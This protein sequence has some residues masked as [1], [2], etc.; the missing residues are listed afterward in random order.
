[1]NFI[2]KLKPSKDGIFI[3]SIWD[4]GFLS[5]LFVFVNISTSTIFQ[6]VNIPMSALNMIVSV[7]ATIIIYL[8]FRRKQLTN[9]LF[10]II[11]NIIVTFLSICF[12]MFIMNYTMDVT[13]DG[14]YYHKAAIGAIKEGWNP[15]YQNHYDF[16]V[17]NN[18]SIADEK[19]SLWVNSYPKA[20]WNFAASV[21]CV[22]NNIESG[23]AIIILFMISLFCMTFS[24]AFN[25]GFKI[26]QAFLIAFILCM[27]PIVM[28]QLFSYYVDGIMGL[29]IYMTILFL[30]IISDRNYTLIS[31]N[32]KWLGL[33]MSVCICMNIKFTGIL[34][35][36]IFCILFY[37]YWLFKS[38]KQADFKKQF[39]NLTLRFF[40][41]VIVGIGAIGFS[42]Y[43]K[44]IIN[45]NNPLYPLMGKDKVD[46]V[47]T[48]QPKS[49]A[50]KNRFVKLF[51]SVFAESEN[52]TYNS[53]DDPNLKI[54]FTYTGKEIDESSIPDLRIGGYGI[55]F[56]G[57]LILTVA[58]IM[59]TYIHIYIYMRKK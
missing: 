54:P 4:I 44:N 58:I 6:F 33:L 55:L 27:S 56:S 21:Y 10:N 12:V 20:T 31:E 43:M 2:E 11:V 28:S 9:N 15:V 34:F 40:V 46:I 49:F 51:E 24:Y 57:I 18:P 47:T 5:L 26:I 3:K 22:T 41:I 16:N 7:I 13:A 53:G 25:K 14:N 59:Y 17:E 36:G 45:H 52:V 8:I 39:I 19:T 32:E 23:K 38:R 1:M 48:M 35:T 37:L 30:L 29:L 50:Q 42:T